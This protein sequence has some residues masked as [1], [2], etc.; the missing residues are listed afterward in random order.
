MAGQLRDQE[1]RAGIGKALR[2]LSHILMERL[3]PQ[4]GRR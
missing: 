2:L 3:Y 4:R 1:I